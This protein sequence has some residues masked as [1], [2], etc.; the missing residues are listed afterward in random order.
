MS[1]I[2]IAEVFVTAGGI[3]TGGF[4]VGISRA[5]FKFLKPFVVEGEQVVDTGGV[6]PVAIRIRLDRGGGLR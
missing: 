1:P 6:V 5:V 2:G 4:G 3:Y